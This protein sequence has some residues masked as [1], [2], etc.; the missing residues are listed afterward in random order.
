MSIPRLGFKNETKGT[1]S[2]SLLWDKE[3]T[4]NVD[5]F[6]YKDSIQISNKTYLDLYENKSIDLVLKVE[7]EKLFYEKHI[8]LRESKK[9]SIPKKDIGADEI[10]ISVYFVALKD[11][12]LKTNSDSFDDFYTEDFDVI[13]GQVVS[14]IKVKYIYPKISSSN[15]IAQL[16][17]IV[18]DPNIRDEFE[19]DL[20]SDLPTLTIKNEDVYYSINS[21][22]K[23]RNYQLLTDSVVLGPIFVELIRMI[24]E[25][26]IDEE[27]KWAEDLTKLLGYDSIEQLRSQFPTGIGYQDYYKEAYQAYNSKLFGKKIMPDLMKK[28]EEI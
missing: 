11:F 20:Q 4:D 26:R 28:I 22:R 8:L 7:F 9:L 1:F 6:I 18:T 13:K 2:F 23:K 14:E 27:Y 3:L 16:L 24:F 5:F 19:I 12:I 21:N 10:K 17:K 25:N 15:S